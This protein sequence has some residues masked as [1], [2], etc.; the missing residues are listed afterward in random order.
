[1]E[2]LILTTSL[3]SRIIRSTIPKVMKSRPETDGRGL[4]LKRRECRFTISVRFRI[5]LQQRT[6]TETCLPTSPSKNSDRSSAKTPKRSNHVCT[7]K[8][9]WRRHW[10]E[11]RQEDQRLPCRLTAPK[12]LYRID[13]SGSSDDSINLFS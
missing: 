12:A 2:A 4:F 9:A 1:M 10:T 7:V 11:S 3:S 13:I 8:S 5:Y 6:C